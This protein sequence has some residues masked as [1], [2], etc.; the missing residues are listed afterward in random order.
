MKGS[1]KL[2]LKGTSRDVSLQLEDFFLVLNAA[3]L[4][5]ILGALWYTGLIVW[6][7]Q[8]VLGLNLV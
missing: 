4:L 7:V 8:E 6:L 2:A 1:L 3:M 5:T